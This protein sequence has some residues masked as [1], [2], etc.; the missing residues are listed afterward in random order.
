M[1]EA[2]VRVT[3]PADCGSTIIGFPLAPLLAMVPAK[4]G[5]DPF[6]IMIIVPGPAVEAAVA[7]CA[8][9]FTVVV[10]AN[11]WR[12]PSLL[13]YTPIDNISEN[14]TTVDAILPICAEVDLMWY[15]QN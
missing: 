6:A 3:P 12:A 14:A 9:E 11:A 2:P 5:Y 10:A 15:M 1:R 8:D 7:N 4:P 13:R